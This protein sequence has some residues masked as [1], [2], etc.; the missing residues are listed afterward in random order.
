MYLRVTR[1]H[2]DPARYDESVTISQEIA[3]AIARMPG[4]VSYRGGGDRATGAIVAVSTWDTEEH[5]RF[6]R[7]ALGGVLDRLLA[8]GAHLEAEEFYD[9]VVER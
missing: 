5:A 6:S 1:G 2:F 3:D 4:L 8:A 7:E 9:V